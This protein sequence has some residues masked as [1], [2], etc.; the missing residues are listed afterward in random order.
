MYSKHSQS[1][2]V[3]QKRILFEKE[4]W[5]RDITVEFNKSQFIACLCSD[6]SKLLR[7]NWGNR[8]NNIL[9]IQKPV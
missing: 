1:D 5:R 3:L 9:K 4:T 6:P 7:S 2:L 8:D